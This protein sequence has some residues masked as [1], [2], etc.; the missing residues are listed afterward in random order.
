MVDV[1]SGLFPH[2]RQLGGRLRLV[3]QPVFGS[4]GNLDVDHRHDDQWY[5][6]GAARRVDDVASLL[7][8]YAGRLLREVLGPIVPSY[9][10]WGRDNHADHPD[11]GNHD[12]H[13][14][15][16]SLAGVVDGIVDRPVPVQGDGGEVQDGRRV[17]QDV[18]REPHLADRQSNFHRDMRV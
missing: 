16:S 1:V 9:E 2:G 3:P 8:E 14:L 13:P 17:A 12:E 11:G 7:G 5:V 10:G 6:E 18:A 15:Q 4:F